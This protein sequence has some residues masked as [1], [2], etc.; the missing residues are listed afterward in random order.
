MLI[1]QQLWEGVLR[2]NNRNLV[3][4]SLSDKDRQVRQ[5]R[6]EVTGERQADGRKGQE[7]RQVRKG[8][9]DMC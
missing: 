6:S 4:V 7:V 8:E 5:E 2:Q 1:I 9:E 3:Q